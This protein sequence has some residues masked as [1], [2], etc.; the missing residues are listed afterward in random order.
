MTDVE[1]VSIEYVYERLVCEFS[2]WDVC[3]WGL[4]KR[5]EDYWYCWLHDDDPLTYKIAPID[6]NAECDEYLADYRRAYRH[7]FHPRTDYEGWDLDWFSEKWGNRQ[8][9]RD[10]V[11]A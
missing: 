4:I 3:L 7:W 2:H 10:Q 1:I 11:A 6:W 9:I 8:P 5:D